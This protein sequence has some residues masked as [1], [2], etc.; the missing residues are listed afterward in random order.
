MENQPTK[1]DKAIKISIIAGV[2]MASLSVAYYLVVFLPKN[3]AKKT[4]QEP[5]VIDIE[6]RKQ[7]L[8]EFY[9]RFSDAID[10]KDWGIVYEST[11]QSIKAYITK[12]QFI[13]FQQKRTETNE[14]FS[15][16]TIVNGVTVDGEKG[17]VDRTITICLTEECM[18][19]NRLEDNAKKEYIFT[20]G[21][22]HQLDPQPSERA[23]TVATS[24]YYDFVSKYKQIDKDSF[25]QKY[26][27]G[28]GN[29][30]LA[31]R[32]YAVWLDNDM[33]QLI[34]VEHTLNDLKAKNA[35]PTQAPQSNNY[36]SSESSLDKLMREQ[37][38]DCQ[39]DLAKYSSCIAEYNTKLAEY[40]ACL[41][42]ASDPNS[43]RHSSFCSKPFKSCFKP[44]C[45]Y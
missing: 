26:S 2:L 39:Q 25:L 42:E 14:P 20:N 34:V 11:P 27:F 21:K 9:N 30:K 45:A 40:N 29:E 6:S 13:A 28:T 8:A 4:S 43:W 44:V 12:D 3:E 24:V 7:A 16:D 35:V 41:S 10:N 37:Q 38:Q 33:Q 22:W 17:Y 32:Q 19:T 5:Q 23:L 31:I 15:K 18:G 36:Q 1:L